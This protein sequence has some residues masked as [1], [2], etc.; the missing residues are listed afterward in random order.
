MTA[1][2]NPVNILPDEGSHAE[3]GGQE[4]TEP[5][6]LVET[7][8]RFPGFQ[9]RGESGDDNAVKAVLMAVPH[10]ACTECHCML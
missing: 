2:L 8:S 4:S 7:E 6:S 1:W 3:E 10:C 9:Q 5:W